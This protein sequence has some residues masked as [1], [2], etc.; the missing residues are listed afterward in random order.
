MT[1]VLAC[2]AAS[3][4]LCAVAAAQDITAEEMIQLDKFK[5]QY[6]AQGLSL[7][8]EQ[9]AKLVL[10]LRAMRALAGLAP[11]SQGG[12]ASLMQQIERAQQQPAPLV[13]AAR[14][15]AA[16]TED[17]LK[18]QLSALP[19][20]APVGSLKYLSDGLMFDGQRFADAAG[21]AER[22]GVD[23]AT[24]SIGYVVETGGLA[25]MRLARLGTT[26]DPITIGTLRIQGSQQLFE[27]VT[28]K[29]LAGELF[30]P[31]ADG[32]LVL[33][34]SIGFRYKAGDGLR[35]I[36]LPAGWFPTPLQA[37]DVSSTGWLLLEK[38]VSEQKRS[39]LPFVGLVNKIG[40][41]SGAREANEYALMDT[42]TGR[43][44]VLDISTDGQ[45]VTDATQCRRRA[46]VVNVCDQMTTVR[47][48]W[49]KDGSRNFRHYFWRVD[50]QLVRDRPVAVVQ[51]KRSVEVNAY[52]LQTGTK[53]SLFQ[54][55]LGL[56][57]MN[58]EVTADGWLRVTAR[59]GLDTAVVDDAMERL[60]V[61]AR[62]VQ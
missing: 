14:P 46:G 11:A 30:F 12:G 34:D 20:G 33:R 25:T 47:S 54:R 48:A 39:Q 19:P 3:L 61:T 24:G 41:I 2:L 50:W 57:A 51:E 1:R 35:Q 18:Q 42:V 58:A 15:A 62:A 43:M 45:N 26:A 16:I 59:L 27:M 55:A 53:V 36:S 4:Y 22:F 6:K 17:R 44:V 8:P 10:R 5:E 37:G 40:E 29:T 56:S 31:L 9:E 52:D 28:G 60:P 32:A 21:R 38:D 49:D 13:S 7:R 23:R